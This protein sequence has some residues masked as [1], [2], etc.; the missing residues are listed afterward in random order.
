MSEGT[1]VDTP[2]TL[3]E[4][5][6]YNKKDEAQYSWTNLPRVS[7][8]SHILRQPILILSDANRGV[9][10]YTV[11]TI[12]AGLCDRLRFNDPTLRT[13]DLSILPEGVRIGRLLQILNR[14]G[15]KDLIP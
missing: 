5:S 14:Q 2:T 6:K 9:D 7:L 10:P 3:R 4:C 15:T 1:T 11:K 12:L 8:Y 13:L